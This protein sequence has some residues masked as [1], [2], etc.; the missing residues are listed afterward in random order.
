VIATDT[1]PRDGTLRPALQA[2]WHAVAAWSAGPTPPCPGEVIACPRLDDEL[3]E[4]DN[5]SLMGQADELHAQGLWVGRSAE[6]PVAFPPMRAF[7]SARAVRDDLNPMF[8]RALAIAATLL[9]GSTVVF[10]FVPAA[11]GLV[12]TSS[13]PR[14]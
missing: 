3:F 2:D 9:L 8:Y 10:R 14:R 4:G 11:H 12:D 6:G 13:Q 7:D 5:T 1:A